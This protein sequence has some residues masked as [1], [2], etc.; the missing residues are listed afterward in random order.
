M[1]VMD[2]VVIVV[3]WSLSLYSLATVKGFLGRR[4]DRKSHGAGSSSSFAALAS[5]PP[6]LRGLPE[7]NYITGSPE[8]FTAFAWDFIYL[9]LPDSKMPH[10]GSERFGGKRQ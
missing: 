7:G 1:A 8:N 6:G 4:L 9:S 2:I 5:S 3:A 10:L